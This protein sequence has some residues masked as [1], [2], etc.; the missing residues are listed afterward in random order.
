MSYT[1]TEKYRLECVYSSVSSNM[2]LFLPQ[3][4]YEDVDVFALNIMQIFC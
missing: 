4:L 1:I 3:V 2:S